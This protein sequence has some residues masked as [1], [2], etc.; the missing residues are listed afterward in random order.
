ML[1]IHSSK[2]TCEYSCELDY[3]VIGSVCRCKILNFNSNNREVVDEVDG[4]PE[5]A[6][7]EMLLIDEQKMRLLPENLSLH[8]PNLKGLIID[9]SE[10]SSISKEDLQQFPELKFL[11][12]GNNNIEV[13]ENDLFEN[14]EHIEWLSLI[15]NFTKRIGSGILN[16][17]KDLRVANFQRNTCVNFRALRTD[18]ERLKNVFRRDCNF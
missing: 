9:S 2:L 13:L 16:P 11:M 1:Q 8:F 18:F 6:Q 7:V 10:L 4:L 17:L 15:N 3:Q 14:N 5:N 12:I